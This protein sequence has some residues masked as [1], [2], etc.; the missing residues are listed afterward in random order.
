[1]RMQP[2]VGHRRL[3]GPWLRTDELATTIVACAR[4]SIGRHL[5]GAVAVGRQEWTLL[6]DDLVLRTDFGT[7]TLR[8]KAVVD[9]DRPLVGTSWRVDSLISADAVTTSVALERAKPGLTLRADDTVVGW[10]G[11]NTFYGRAQVA[12]Q[13]VPFDAINTSAHRARGDGDVI[14]TSAVL[15]GPVTAVVEADRLT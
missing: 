8:D 5:D 15:T 3:S 6:G 7:V 13:T 1:M 11:C 2:W 12:D 9:P 4:R 10:T 14:A